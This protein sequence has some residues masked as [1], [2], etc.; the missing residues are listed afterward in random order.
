MKTVGDKFPAFSLPGIDENNEFV[1]V[2]IHESYTP[3]K[4][5]WSVVYFYPKDF[6][7]VCPTEIAGMLDGA[8]RVLQTVSAA[9]ELWKF[10]GDFIGL[11]RWLGLEL[12]SN[13]SA[14]PTQTL[15]PV[16]LG[17]AADLARE[18]AKQAETQQHFSLMQKGGSYLNTY[19]KRKLELLRQIDNADYD[20]E[21]SAET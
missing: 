16:P 14:D 3:H 17:D 19:I 10:R 6:T 1:Q 4:K 15:L 11:R 18:V 12:N 20:E 2:D 13:L 5:D 7:F 9:L 8:A 21:T